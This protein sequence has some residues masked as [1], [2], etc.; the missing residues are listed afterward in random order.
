MKRIVLLAGVL[1]S[2]G[3]GYAQKLTHPDLLYTPERIEQI[4]Q[5]IGQDEQMTSAWKEIKQTAEKELKG[6]SLNKADYLSLAYLMTGEKV[7]ADKLK[8]ILLKTIEAETWGSAEMLAR[9]PA[10]RSDLGLA[11]KA[12][13]SAIAYDAVYNDLSA[14]E[15]KKI[16]KGLYRL[17][18]EPLL[19]DWLLE[20]V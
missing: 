16:A 12:Y 2:M 13:L 20:P 7:Y 18:V 5:R 19:G 9:K 6:N 8:A 3:M 1:C 17:G 4:K 15:R 14:S 10:W 11:H